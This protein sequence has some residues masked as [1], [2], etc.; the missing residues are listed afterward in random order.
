MNAVLGTPAGPIASEAARLFEL[1]AIIG[2]VV[3][4]LVLAA[5]VLAV[6][7]G[8][9]RA[10]RT[11]IVVPEAHPDAADERVLARSVT[12]A[13][14]SVVVVLFVLLILDAGAVRRLRAITDPDPLTVTLTGHEW[15]WEVSYADSAPARVVT[16]ANELHLPMG[17]VV[18]LEIRSA[19]VIHSFRAPAIA[20]EKAA[21]PGHPA[22]L[23]LRADR[24]GIYPGRCAEFCGPQHAHMDLSVVVE[25]PM[26]FES[27]LDAQRAPAREPAT[28]L[29]TEG[30]DVFLR[31]PCALCH[32]VHG[33]DARAVLGPDL[34][35]LASRATLA[36]GAV[37]NAP[38]YLAGW[39]TDP[40]GIKPGT[41][42]PATPL[43][44]G[45]LRAL[46]AYLASLK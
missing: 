33:T 41:R 28:P 36:A 44:P 35:H 16:T 22:V 18:K 39:I 4:A 27:W 11:A 14:F 23:W 38:G 21:I 8:A 46:T 3:L 15:W 12:G 40:G 34:T 9:R 45:E 25:P 42:M 17:R 20:G 10:R 24:P 7:R 30:R 26:A 19:D 29:E 13:A 43:H 37:P 1:F 2:I 5:L 31:S 32:A 6:V